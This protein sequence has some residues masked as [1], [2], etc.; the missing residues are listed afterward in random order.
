MS[1]YSA[2]DQTSVRRRTALLVAGLG[3]ALLVGGWLLWQSVRGAFTNPD[4]TSIHLPPELSELLAEPNW[5][6]ALA[7]IE[8]KGEVQ[9]AGGQSTAGNVPQCYLQVLRSRG[10]LDLDFGYRVQ[11]PD[12]TT[13]ER[14]LLTVAL[15][16]VFDPGMQVAE[17]L[18]QKIRAALPAYISGPHGE[19]GAVDDATQD[20]WLK[21]AVAQNDPDRRA[22]ADKLLT[23]VNAWGE[24][25]L[26]AHKDEDAA[27]LVKLA[28]AISP[29]QEQL[30][31]NQYLALQ[32]SRSPVGRGISGY[33]RRLVPGAS[34]QPTTRPARR[35]RTRPTG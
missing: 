6:R 16:V 15:A 4:T 34:P 5:P 33:M 10:S 35:P 27:M 14:R 2:N 29:D 30:L 7:T 20:A 13:A 1:S 26:P 28:A 11:N 22:A 23:L 19:I 31:W 24:K 32:Q 12:F 25:W 9:M 18:R 17:D 8:G 3:L 21:F